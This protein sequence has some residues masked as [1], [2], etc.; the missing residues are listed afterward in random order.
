MI[1]GHPLTSS[2]LAVVRDPPCSGAV[3]VGTDSRAH[4][5]L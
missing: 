5:Q 2:R 1:V 3:H 4:P